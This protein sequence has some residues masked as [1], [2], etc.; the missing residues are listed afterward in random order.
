LDRGRRQDQ[1]R[2]RVHARRGAATAGR[3]ADD[4]SR[5][6][7]GGIPQDRI[8]I[9]F[10]T[11]AGRRK[12]IAEW[13][14]AAQTRY[15]KMAQPGGLS[16]WRPKRY[17]SSGPSNGGCSSFCSASENG[18]TSSTTKVCPGALADVSAGNS[19][20]ISSMLRNWKI[21]SSPIE[22]A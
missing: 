11:G 21:R 20:S 4:E 5:G 1:T 6:A 13:R 22:R 19:R 9:I 18:S 17:L 10:L 3:R 14:I 15:P 7:A 8:G 2:D 16:R 12:A